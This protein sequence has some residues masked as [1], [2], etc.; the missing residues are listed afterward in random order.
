[1]PG[2]LGRNYGSAD[3]LEP[4]CD[5]D[6]C[7]NA[8]LPGPIGVHHH[9]PVRVADAEKDKT[10]K[11]STKG[12][13]DTIIFHLYMPITGS[14]TS[15]KF[16]NWLQGIS[17]EDADNG[18]DQNVQI[19]RFE[20]EGLN[21]EVNTNTKSGV[22]DFKKSLQ[23]E[24]AVVVYLGHSALD[25]YHGNSSLGL[26]PQGKKEPEIPNRELRSH[27]P[28]STASLVIIASCDSMT[29]VGTPTAGPA[30]IVTNSGADKTTWSTHWAYALGTFFFLL[31]GLELD[32]RDQPAIKRKGGHATISE[33]LKAS[34]DE[35]AKL[36]TD[37]RFKLVHGDGSKMLFA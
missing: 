8:Q 3:A 17:D 5:T 15:Q 1:M 30:I 36:G 32:A 11:P 28:K 33:A 37:D 35:F 10:K 29:A 9:R 21:L 12:K 27:L 24:G 20:A 16:I 6:G 4:L 2:P 13:I 25:Q 19:E 31:I 18:P 7:R 14:F 23:R 22:A 34:D 26:T